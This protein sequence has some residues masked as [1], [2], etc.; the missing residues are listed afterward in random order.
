M[1]FKYSS[2]GGVWIKVTYRA[3]CNSRD[4]APHFN[5][6]AEKQ[7]AINIINKADCGSVENNCTFIRLMPDES[8]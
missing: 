5:T 8:L 7:G 4:K 3:F 2:G 6:W 1:A